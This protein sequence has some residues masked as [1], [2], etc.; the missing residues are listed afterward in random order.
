MERGI[1]MASLLECKNGRDLPA[2]IKRDNFDKRNFWLVCDGFNV[3]LAEQRVG[4]S[5]TQ[6]IRIPKATFD[7][8]VKKYTEQQ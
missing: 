6:S 8:F 5:P 4:E 7:Y 3:T 2:T 1:K